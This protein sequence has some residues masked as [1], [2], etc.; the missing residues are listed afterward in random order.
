M[1]RA[2][3]SLRHKHRDVGHDTLSLIQM[4]AMFTPKYT[5]NEIIKAYTVHKVLDGWMSGVQAGMRMKVKGYG[6]K[7]TTFEV[8]KRMSREVARL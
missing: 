5:P 4:L 2:A 3:K 6:K 8:I 7:D 1:D